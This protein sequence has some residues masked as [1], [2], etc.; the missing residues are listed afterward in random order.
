MENSPLVPESDSEEDDKDKKKSKRVGGVAVK[1][2]SPRE[3]AEVQEE[4]KPEPTYWERLFQKE[5]EKK[6]IEKNE[7]THEQTETSLSDEDIESGKISK[8]EVEEVVGPQVVEVIKELKKD[9]E[10]D[11]ATDPPVDEFYEHYESTGD[12]DAAFN[13]VMDKLG[14]SEED[15]T[16][17][18]LEPEHVENEIAEMAQEL[19]E[20]EVLIDLHH[21][22]SAEE[23]E[24]DDTAVSTT[25]A[26][27]APPSGTSSG[28][29]AGT[30]PSPPASPPGSPGGPASPAGPGRFYNPNLVPFPATATNNPNLAPQ[31]PQYYD[32][33]PA[34]MALFG[35]IIGYLIGRR[36]GRIKTEKKLL[37]VQKKLEKEVIA[38]QFD[39]QEKEK[40][41]RRVA[42][43]KVKQHGPTVIEVFKKPT[44]EK[45]PEVRQKAPEAQRL[46][47]S[48]RAPEHLGS[49]LIKSEAKPASEREKP[50]IEKKPDIEPEQYSDRRVETLNREELLKLSEKIVVEGSSL[51]TIYENHLI[52]ERGLRRLVNEYMRGG[53][54]K[55][56][57]QT[58]IVEREIDFERDPHLRDMAPTNMSGG[59]V[60]GR[61][62]LNQMLAK[63]SAQVGVANEQTAFVKAKAD[64]ESQQF[65]QQQE[66]RRVLDLALISII[67]ILLALV[68]FLAVVRR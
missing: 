14:V 22:A 34:A 67:L 65:R 1:R 18:E 12:Q 58:E 27:A 25:K 45:Q 44:V 10:A 57:L 29:T 49:M 26:S 40:K 5:D 31:S 39:L 68:V 64:Y 46:H 42:A 53:D 32:S 62:A 23:V 59:G 8:D 30:P 11:P 54:I 20:D 15:I 51:R 61:V 56:A 38:L 50:S 16:K 19:D 47:V 66:Q 13:F 17:A 6:K 4:K 9:Q 2:E 63:A 48:E 36:R 24:E 60:G 3:K 33:S 35:G 43:E 37:P 7:S 28:G 52:G 55:K 21:E 41:I